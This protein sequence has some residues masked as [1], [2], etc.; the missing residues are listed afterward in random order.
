[1]AAK[2]AQAWLSSAQAGPL[3]GAEGS[4]K[5]RELLAKPLPEFPAGNVVVG[6]ELGSWQPN[7]VPQETWRIGNRSVNMYY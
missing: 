1:M 7:A 5:A 4:V 2:S 3:L 6:D